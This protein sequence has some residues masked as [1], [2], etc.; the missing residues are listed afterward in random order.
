MREVYPNELMHH[1]ILGQRWGVRRYQNK[2]GTL[3]DLGKKRYG[4]T[5]DD[6]VF[7]SGK[8]KYD[9]PIDD[10]IKKQ[11][12]AIIDAGANI[13]IGDAPGADKRLQDY[14]A[15]KGYD[16]VKVYSADLEVRNNVGNWDVQYTHKKGQILNK[17]HKIDKEAE[18]YAAEKSGWTP[19]KNWEASVD[20]LYMD[21]GESKA[22]AI[23]KK[24]DDAR[25]EYK[26]DEWKNLNSE[27]FKDSSSQRKREKEMREA[28]RGKD[29]A[30]TSAS[31]KALAVMPI[32]DRRGSAMSKNVK[33]LKKQH[34]PVAIYDYNTGQF[35]YK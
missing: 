25:S 17:I 34:K 10:S 7:L 5:S 12:D 13:V 2:D 1:G 16:K 29:E 35:Y 26:H 32:D 6:T 22:R 14:I 15:E 9:Q 8:V 11:V 33:R 24:Y 23:V 30:M 4:Y 19:G 27:F 3:T 21:V 18:Q 28:R 20:K 31:T